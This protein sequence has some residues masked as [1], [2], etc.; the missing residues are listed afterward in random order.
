VQPLDKAIIRNIVVSA[1]DVVRKGQV[2]ATLDPTFAAA[3]LA[4]LQ[5]KVSSLTAETRRIEAEQADQPFMPADSGAYETLQAKIWAQRQ[6]EYHA[7]IADF[8]ERI[9]AAE[10]QIAGLTEDIDRYQTRLKIAL[11]QEKM[12]AELERRGIESHL[13]YLI[14]F[15]QR[16]EIERNMAQSRNNMASTRHT[17][18]S[19]KSQR[20]VYVEKWRDDAWATLVDRRNQLD[21]ARQDLTKAEKLRELSDLVAPEDAV[22]LRIADR[23]VGSVALEGEALFTLVP[24]SAPLEAKVQ[25]ETKDIGFPKPGDPVTIKFEAYKYMEHGT[26]VGIVKTISEDSLSSS[27]PGSTADTPPSAAPYFEARIEI[28]SLKLHDVPPNFRIIPG[29]AVQTDI[30]VGR[31]SIMWYL[32]GSA[33]RSGA[34]AMHEP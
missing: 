16:V 18:E 1:G 8:D 30:T 10:A 7:G 32:L 21:T 2:L 13:Q 14:A 25:I 11:E 34:E 26:G 6:A 19:L 9:G 22:V 17:M 3:D 31:R 24:L 20:A 27:T 29:M 15:D 5:D 23:S 12:R 33:L 28:T 4:Q